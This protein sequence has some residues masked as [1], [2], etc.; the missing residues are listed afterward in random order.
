MKS[1]FLHRQP[2]G[3][4]HFLRRFVGLGLLVLA[5]LGTVRLVAQGHGIVFDGSQSLS[6]SRMEVADLGPQFP[7]DWSDFEALVLE[8]R[9]SSSQRF[10][11]KVF[12]GTEGK[13]SRV[14]VQ[15][16]AGAWVRA[17]I[18][19]ALL[20]AAP[21]SGY[22]MASVG[23]RSR[24]GYFLGLWGPFIP[25]KA[26]TALGFAMENPIGTPRLEMSLASGFT[27]IGRAKPPRSTCSKPRGPTK[28][29][30]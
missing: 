4:F 18:P 17:A 21:A 19:I 22:D 7:R 10:S 29:H 6:E 25:L 11:L 1:A 5:C 13:F 3:R 30:N 15:P 12:S 23:N 20:S 16:Y 9:A 26:V 24:P 14:L 28:P 27:P 8:M 2:A